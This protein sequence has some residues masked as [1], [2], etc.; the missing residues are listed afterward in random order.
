MKTI[1]Y[2]FDVESEGKTPSF[3]HQV[4]GSDYRE[5]TT[6][7]SVN[8]PDADAVVTRIAGLGIHIFTADCLP[9]LLYKEGHAVAA[10]HCGWRGALRGVVPRA[11]KWF[12]GTREVRAILG[13]SLHPCCFEVKNDFVQAFAGAGKDISRYL[14]TRAGKL[15]FDLPRYVCD[16][17]LGLPRT[18]V[19]LSASRCTYCSSSELPSYRR[20]KGTDPRIRGWILRSS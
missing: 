4:H 10:V 8:V 18:A 20:N 15:F 2:G 17:E 6:G 9:V 19:D 11:L 7:P 14:E 1:S 13:P 5:V 16:V 3:V 12:G